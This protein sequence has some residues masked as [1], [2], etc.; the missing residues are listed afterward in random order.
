MEIKIRPTG[1]LIE[2]LRVLV[3]KQYVSDSRGWSLPGGKLEPGE[4]IGGCLVRELKE[5]TGLDVTVKELIYVT[6]RFVQPDSH[7]VH[8][9]FL[10]ER[11]RPG[12]YIFEWTHEDTSSSRAYS[13][14]RLVKLVP[15]EELTDYGFTP[16]FQRLI[17]AGFPG[18]GS[19]KGD[20]HTFYGE[21]P[22]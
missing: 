22:A 12:H 5:E 1:I 7:I 15:I 9:L 16:V 18:L 3:T 17:L 20:F 8:M 13:N 10:I 11:T 4:T 19:Y 2:D 21:K 6:D 14:P